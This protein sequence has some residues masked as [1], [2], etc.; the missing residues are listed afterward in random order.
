MSAAM[1]YADVEA[2]LLGPTHDD[3]VGVS[4]AIL[5]YVQALWFLISR[6]SVDKR[7][8]ELDLC[9]E[10]ARRDR[11]I[12]E[13]DLE[14]GRLEQELRLLREK[15]RMTSRNSSKPPSSD[16]PGTRKPRP[17][18]AKG[19]RQ[20]GGQVG[21]PFH[22]RPLVPAE[23]IP[24]D[25]IVDHRPETCRACAHPLEGDD[26]APHRHQIVEIPVPAPLVF[27]HRLHSLCCPA[28]GERTRASLPD[29]VSATGFGPGVEAVVATLW[30]ACRLSHRMI[31]DVMRD[32]FGV[33][34]ALSTVSNL[35]ARG[36]RAVEARVEEARAHVTTADEAKNVDETGWF[37][38]GADGSNPKGAK[39]WL[40]VAVTQS[41]AAFRVALSRSQDMAKTMVGTLTAGVLVSD[42]YLG[43]RFVG[44]F[45]RQVCWAHLMRDFRRI[46][47]RSGPSTR[48][49]KG[50]LKVAKK[51][52]AAWKRYQEGK[53]DE[54]QWRR[55]MG[56][57]RQRAR[58]LLE[59]GA[60]FDTRENEKSERTMTKNTCAELLKL[61][62]A[63]WLFVTRPEVGITNNV[64]ERSLRH[65]VLWRRASFGSQSARGAQLVAVMLTVVMTKRL[66]GESVHAYFLEACRAAR[67]GRE[68]PSLL[69]ASA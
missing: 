14:L 10:I 51:V 42:R 16:P 31:S 65:A 63:L 29:S 68:A 28:C 39:A 44:V 52:F 11:V 26:P 36:G 37:Q 66:R 32:L 46:S 35:L 17:A 60:R 67:E 2:R 48:I 15:G 49:G 61:E 5:R 59:Q 69:K 58:E 54:E 6:L 41:V 19:K 38:R 22:A 57:L 21:H 12:A 24:R 25:Q 33:R 34:L 45:N 8:L 23:Q 53:L 62:P 20:R 4:H 55:Q 27:E 30:S 13:K 64:A 7:I 9:E 1:G 43:Y 3:W 50:L 18:R 40:W 56:E 47:E